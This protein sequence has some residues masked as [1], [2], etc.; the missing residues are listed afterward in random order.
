MV[1]DEIQI[2]QVISVE[3]VPDVYAFSHD[4]CIFYTSKKV[5]VRTSD[6]ALHSLSF[7]EVS[8]TLPNPVDFNRYKFL[9]KTNNVA[10]PL[11]NDAKEKEKAIK[12]A[13]TRILTDIES[14]KVILISTYCIREC[15]EQQIIF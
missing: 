15:K 9:C 12:D 10:L 2:G 5:V 13:A 8:N 3:E 1:L 4:D 11:E 6:R 7:F 14:Y